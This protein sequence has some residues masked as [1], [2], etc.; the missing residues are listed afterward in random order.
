M[1]FSQMGFTS[2]PKSEYQ[3]VIFLASKCTICRFYALPLKQLHQEFS[4]QGIEFQGV[5]PNARSTRQQIRDFKSKY[6]IPF[7][8]GLDFE[9]LARKLDASV[10]PEVFILNQDNQTLYSGRID[11]SYFGVGKKRTITTKNELRDALTALVNGKEIPI[12]HAPA[13]GCLI[14]KSRP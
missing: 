12:K 9:S 10:T 7:E 5:F 13:V 6:K 3:V 11:N 2:A 14:E 8:M 4:S 1:V